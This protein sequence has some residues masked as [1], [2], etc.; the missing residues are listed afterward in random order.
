MGA[1][2]AFGWSPCIGP[3]LGGILTLAAE[4]ANLGRGV[5]LLLAYSAGLAVPFIASALALDR[6]SG[7]LAWVKRHFRIVNLCS[8]LFMASFGVLLL[9]GRIT[10][11]VRGMQLALRWLGLDGLARSL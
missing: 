3:V 8:G 11:V 9:T 5:F 7:S 6:L 10:E 4:S 2:F 1:A